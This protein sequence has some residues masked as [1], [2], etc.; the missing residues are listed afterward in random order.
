MG[1]FD[2]FKK[3]KEQK[4]EKIVISAPDDENVE[5]VGWKA[6]E[7]E[8]LRVY[9]DQDNPKH[10]G[11]MIKW[12]FGGKD[13]LDGI[14]VYDGGDYWHFVS[15]GL[16]EIYGKESDN[17]DISGYGYE[18]TFKLK[19]DEYEN[20]EAEIKNI[21]G[22]LQ[23]VARIT[24]TAGEIFRPNEFIYTGQTTGID[25]NQKSNLTGFITIKD[26]V[27]ETISTPN[28]QVEFLE[29][30]GMTDAELKSLSDRASVENIY[31]KLKSD[32]TDYHRVSVI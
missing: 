20:E 1:L 31:G 18:L 24:F 32:V 6:I 11:T 4:E 23:M 21:C 19:K 29:L 7:K 13:P 5:A 12:I 8:F 15:F 25:A 22:I 28:G 14:S 16:T 27:V 10:Y 30:I 9:P 17:P 2:K 3:E 26:P